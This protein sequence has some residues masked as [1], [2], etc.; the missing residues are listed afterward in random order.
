MIFTC[1]KCGKVFNGRKNYDATGIV[2]CPNPRCGFLVFQ[3][4]Q[5]N[6]YKKDRMR[7]DLAPNPNM[8]MAEWTRKQQLVKYLNERDAEKKKKEERG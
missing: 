4:P 5:L 7:K 6:R 8:N 3:E 1:G 2:R